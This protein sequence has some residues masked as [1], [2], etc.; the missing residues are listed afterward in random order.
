VAGGHCEISSLLH[1]VVIAMQSLEI[2][3]AL[4]YTTALTMG[5]RRSSAYVQLI[6]AR[7]ME[8]EGS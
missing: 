2:W 8:E 3:R 4:S 1:F 7:S 6:T 5:L